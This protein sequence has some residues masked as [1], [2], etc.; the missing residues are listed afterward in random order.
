[1]EE[2]ARIQRRC[3]LPGFPAYV[4][5]SMHK[6]SWRNCLENREGGV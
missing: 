6:T 2:E 5:P 4:L 3:S 1:M